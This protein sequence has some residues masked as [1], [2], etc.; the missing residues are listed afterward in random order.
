MLPA[1]P[2]QIVGVLQATLDVDGYRVT[3]EQYRVQNS[4]LTL[5]ALNND[6]DIHISCTG[7]GNGRVE[8]KLQSE[9]RTVAGTIAAQTPEHFRIGLRRLFKEL[10]YGGP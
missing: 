7:M 8:L 9:D 6:Q 4:R 3:A 5:R 2:R 10:L 1:P